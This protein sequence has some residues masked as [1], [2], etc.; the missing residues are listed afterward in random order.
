MTWLMVLPTD[1]TYDGNS[2][3]SLLASSLLQLMEGWQPRGMPPAGS[4][5]LRSPDDLSRAQ[6]LFVRN[7]LS[8]RISDVVTPRK[9]LIWLERPSSEKIASYLSVCPF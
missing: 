8:R 7:F 3:R 5:L 9:Q 6:E 2:P 4:L 1:V